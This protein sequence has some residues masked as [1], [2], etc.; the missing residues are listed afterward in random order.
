MHNRVVAFFCRAI[1]PEQEMK[2][3]SSH[4]FPYLYEKGNMFFNLNRV[5]KY[6]YKGSVFIVE[7]HLDCISM[8][9]SGFKNTIAM[10]GGKMTEVQ[11]EIIYRYFDKVYF[12][13][14]NDEPG[15]NMVKFWYDEE[16][17]RHIY[18]KKYKHM[19]LY[20]IQI[21]MEGIKDVNDL[22]R[23]GIDIKKYFKK[24]KERME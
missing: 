9:Q 10:C 12:V 22:L 23:K 24:I 8:V 16:D 15:K 5:L 20:K 6:N 11:H 7:G 13:L 4:N 18:R 3:M 2:H 14:D 19:D 1:D 21:D 17:S